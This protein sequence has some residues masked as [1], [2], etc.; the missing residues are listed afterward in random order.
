[1]GSTSTRVG[2]AGEDLPRTTFPTSYGID[3]NQQYYVGET[4]INTWRADM[5]IKNPME[6]GL[7]KDWD[8]VEQIWQAAYTSMLR[9][10]SAEHPLLC[11]EPA[12]NTPENREKM[13]Q[14]AFETFDV[15][16]FYVAKDAVLTAYIFWQ[17]QSKKEDVDFL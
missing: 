12:W 13:M 8:A 4:D 11:T 10:S 16:A 5:E 6:D 15:P 2:F 9:V 3:A 17:Y 7:V 14:L 1:M